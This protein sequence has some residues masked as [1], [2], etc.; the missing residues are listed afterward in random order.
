[1]AE[2]LMLKDKGTGK[3]MRLKQAEAQSESSI[4]EP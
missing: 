3:S 1:M 4:A 2:I